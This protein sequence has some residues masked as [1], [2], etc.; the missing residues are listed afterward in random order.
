MPNKVGELVTCSYCGYTW[1][2]RSIKRFISCPNCL[3]KTKNQKVNKEENPNKDMK[4]KTINFKINGKIVHKEDITKL[5]R[6]DIEL[7]KESISKRENMPKDWIE[8][9]KG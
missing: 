7:V 8:I 1:R 2:V 3:Q 4:D 9:E 5:K 6:G